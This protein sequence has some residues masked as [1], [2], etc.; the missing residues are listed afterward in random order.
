M[1]GAKILTHA[2]ISGKA[3]KERCAYDGRRLPDD[4]NLHLKGSHWLNKIIIDLVYIDDLPTK[5]RLKYYYDFLHNNFN[6]HHNC[7]QHLK[8]TLL[9]K[10]YLD[11]Y[12]VYVYYLEKYLTTCWF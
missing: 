10:L 3:P 7:L 6:A 4:I 5:L 1:L 2:Y 12:Y 9:P 8:N 11:I